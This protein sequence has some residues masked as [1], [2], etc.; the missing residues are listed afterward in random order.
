M[1]RPRSVETLAFHGAV[2]ILL[3]HALD[4]AVLHR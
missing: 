4:D 3:V 1:S 2:S